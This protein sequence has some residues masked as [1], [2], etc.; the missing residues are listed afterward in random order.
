MCCRNGPNKK[1]G[2]KK[3]PLIPHDD[4]DNDDEEDENEDFMM[5]RLPA[6]SSLHHLLEPMFHAHLIHIMGALSNRTICK[7]CSAWTLFVVLLSN[8]RQN[9]DCC[10]IRCHSC[11]MSATASRSEVSSSEVLLPLE[12]FESLIFQGK[13]RT[14]T[15]LF[16]RLCRFSDFLQF[17]DDDVHGVH[18]EIAPS[19]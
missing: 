4:D 7:Y 11:I 5:T 2:I 12:N 3:S 14:L 15:G 1:Y 9:C 18:L 10:H 16:A 6:L 17:D 13:Y 8:I 19:Q